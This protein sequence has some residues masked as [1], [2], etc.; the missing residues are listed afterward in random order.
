M[1]RLNEVKTQFSIE[2]CFAFLKIAYT[3]HIVQSYTSICHAL[4]LNNESL[5]FLRRC[6]VTVVKLFYHPTSIQLVR[7]RMWVLEALLIS[8]CNEFYA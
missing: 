8:D 5:L 7:T 2:A 3:L 6:I 4:N 1:P